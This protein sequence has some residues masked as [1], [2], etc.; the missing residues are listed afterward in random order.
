M[1]LLLRY[2]LKRSEPPRN[3]TCLG[4]A[5]RGLVRR[6][7]ALLDMCFSF[8]GVWNAKRPS[9]MARAFSCGRAVRS[10]T[11]TLADEVK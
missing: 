11:F 2:R 8:F 4:A 6:V 3:Y 10:S 5:I 7:E 9:F 1:P